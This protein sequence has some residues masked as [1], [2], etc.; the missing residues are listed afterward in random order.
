MKT[1]TETIEILS[2]KQ[3]MDPQHHPMETDEI[4]D[5]L[6]YLRNDRD[7]LWEINKICQSNDFIKEHYLKDMQK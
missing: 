4:Q 2:L 6:W 7:L 5:A 1:L 3:H